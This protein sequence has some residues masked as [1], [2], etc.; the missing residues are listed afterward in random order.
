MAKKYFGRTNVIDELIEV[1]KNEYR[2][3]SVIA[4]LPPNTHLKFSMLLSRSSIKTL[5]PWYPDDRWNNN[6][7][8]TYVLTTPG[9]DIV[10]F[11][12][13]VDDLSTELQGVIPDERFRVEAIKDI[14]LYSNKSYEPETPGSAKTVSYVALIGLIVIVIAWVNY[15]NLS[16]ARSVERAR[17]VGI[18]KVMGSLR[19]QLIFQF[20]A[21]SVIVNVVAG[22]LA[23]VLLQVAFPFFRDLSGQPIS[24]D[25]GQDQ[26]FWLIFIGL[27]GVGSILSGIYPAFVLSSFNP[28]TVLK[29][30]FHSSS[31]GRALRKGL[32]IF[33]FSAT[34]VLLISMCTVYLQVEY[35]RH[36]D[37]GMNIDQTLVLTG[38]QLNV[39]DS[40][41]RQTSHTLKTELLA[42]PEIETVSRASALP[43]V[44]IQQLSTTHILRLGETG[45]EGGGYLY[46]FFGVDADFIPGM[47]MTLVG[48]R[49]FE[50]GVPNHDQVII[51]E[52]AAK[53]LGFTNSENAIGAKITF[54]MRSKSEGSTIIGV[55]KNFYFRSPK[56]SNLPILLYYGEPSDYFALTVSTGNLKKTVASI[57]SV[58]E[59]V[60]PK[61]VFNYFFLNEQYDNQ[62]RADTQFGK[63]M[64]ALSVLIVLIACLGLFGLSS[65]TIL[66]RT[67]EIGI[68]K[69]LGA[70]STSI[71]QLLTGSFARTVLIASAIALPV[72]YWLMIEW[73]AAYPVRISL[74]VWIFLI[75]IGG[76]LLLAMATVS[77][78]T[79]KTAMA[80][81]TDSLRQE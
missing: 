19:K 69:V 74:N 61:T 80:N 11:S 23:L 33:Q 62:Y 39:S 42:I 47:G 60:Y 63:V 26:S 32:V 49:N 18:R 37:L 29:G 4:D 77:V 78:Q 9:T 53:L 50:D 43:G 12:K 75:S 16:T 25:F 30:K 35:L 3:K 67:K 13:K 24:P 57:Q 59:K 79:F 1:D 20:L 28:V 46:Y 81:P 72:G 10:Q 71:V 48:G 21:E 8:Y 40:L 66:Q 14:H 45:K 70:S 52:E 34:I 31:H 41:F 44:D 73:L 22:A 36:Y 65:Y 56:E 38:K 7:E 58:W 55:L 17:E 68:R 51:N 5:M 64:G 6:N 54:K 15:I 2:V 76:V 27:L